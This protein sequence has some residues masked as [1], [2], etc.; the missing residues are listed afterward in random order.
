MTI[1][2]G[3]RG[4]GGSGK[5]CG[6]RCGGAARYSPSMGTWAHIIRSCASMLLISL[7]LVLAL[8]AVR[9]F[10]AGWWFPGLVAVVLATALA[11]W[12]W[13]VVQ[14]ALADEALRASEQYDDTCPAHQGPRQ[15]TRESP[16][17]T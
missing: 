11:G 13:Q 17:E 10:I 2:F 12:F 9:C 1:V 8:F 7:A 15:R 3:A 5:G 6:V 16:V 4:G 14:R